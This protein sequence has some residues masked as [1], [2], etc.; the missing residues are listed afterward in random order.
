MRRSLIFRIHCL[1]FALTLGG[2]ASWGPSPL[3]K[4][5]EAALEKRH[6]AGQMETIREA[7]K[8]AEEKLESGDRLRQQGRNE[9]AM[10]AYFAAIRMDPAATEPRER[11]GFLHLEHD[12]DRAEAIFARLVDED[13]TNANAWRGLGLAHLVRGEFELSREAL[14][15]SLEL[16]PDTPGAHLALASTL[17][18]MG[19][20]NQ[21]LQ[22][23][24]R[25]RDL[26]PRSADAANVVG[27][28]YLLLDQPDQAEEIFSQVVRLA[29]D[30]PAYANNL[31]MAMAAQGRYGD[32]LRAFERAGDEQSAYNNL[33]YAYFLNGDYEMAISQYERALAAPGDEDVLVIRNLNA[34]ITAMEASASAP[35]PVS[36]TTTPAEPRPVPAA[37]AA[38]D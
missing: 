24:L 33:G 1:A 31:G 29:P 6:L 11:I 20:P 15:R 34:A 16:A 13:D 23:A 17:G 21:A 18:L 32:A 37:P 28:T 19:R 25:A 38:V 7:P 9:E 22:H 36:L 26:R 10:M 12:V 27:L 5:Q 4:A 14:E 30:V 35:A 8:T 2:C 3:E